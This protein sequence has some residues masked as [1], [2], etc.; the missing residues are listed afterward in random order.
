MNFTIPTDLEVQIFFHFSCPLLKS[1]DLDLELA[2]KRSFGVLKSLR[3]GE[4]FEIGDEQH[5]L[6]YLIVMGLCSWGLELERKSDTMM[7]L[8]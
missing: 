3:G 6:W 8:G 7:E 4:G 1:Y 5:E 2:E